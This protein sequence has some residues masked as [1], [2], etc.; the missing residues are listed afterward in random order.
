MDWENYFGKDYFEEENNKNVLNNYYEKQEKESEGVADRIEA[1]C[2][3]QKDWHILEIGC[4]YGQI[5]NALSKRGY[6]AYGCDISRYA[7]EH[8]QVKMPGLKIFQADIQHHSF[9]PYTAAK[10]G[11]QKFDL[12]YSCIT[13]EHIFPHNLR[14]VLASLSALTKPNGL[15]YHAIDITCFS[16]KTHFCMLTREQWNEFF[17]RA[18][19]KPLLLHEY[20]IKLNYFM[21]QK[22]EQ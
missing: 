19:F 3:P 20:F 14:K 10:T 13:M 18:G 11:I 12:I 6:N 1:L 2:K 16:D 21:Y 8:G 15:N 4:A 7:V 5:V 9:A 17:S 22:N